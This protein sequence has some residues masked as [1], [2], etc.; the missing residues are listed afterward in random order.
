MANITPRRKLPA[1]IKVLYELVGFTGGDGSQ[2]PLRNAP[3]VKGQD[4]PF[5]VF[6]TLKVYGPDFRLSD[7]LIGGYYDVHQGWCMV[8][9]VDG[10]LFVESPSG[11]NWVEYRGHFKLVTTTTPPPTTP[12]PTTPPVD[13]PTYLAEV[14]RAVE[15]LVKAIARFNKEA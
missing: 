10:T 3:G 7:D 13:D 5:K 2:G 12:P 8:E 14:G 9:T 6:N 1:A 11:E 15:V 4:L